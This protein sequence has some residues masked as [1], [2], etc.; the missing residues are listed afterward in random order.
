M[1]C[2]YADI[3]KSIREW[4]VNTLPDDLGT[5]RWQDGRTIP[6]VIII[7][8]RQQQHPPTGVEV[9]GLEVVI[10]YPEPD[11]APLMGSFHNSD[12]WAILLKQWDAKR[13]TLEMKDRLMATT[14]YPIVQAIRVDGNVLAGIPESFRLIVQIPN[15][16]G[17]P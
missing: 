13:N 14:I 8:N 12:N 15:F 7:G 11:M 5:Y 17:S 1:T 16:V 4:V 3:A 10:F 6:A 2:T 9:S